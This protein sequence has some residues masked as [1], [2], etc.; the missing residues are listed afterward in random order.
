MEVCAYYTSKFKLRG[1][2]LV[3]SKLRIY[4]VRLY[5]HISNSEVPEEILSDVAAFNISTLKITLF[6]TSFQKQYSYSI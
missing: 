1:N 4:L 6:D 3:N 5:W 2:N